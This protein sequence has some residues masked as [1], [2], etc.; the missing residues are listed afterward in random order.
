[1][2]VRQEQAARAG[3]P[4]HVRQL[5]FHLEQLPKTGDTSR[6][7]EINEPVAEGAREV[8]DSAVAEWTNYYRMT[9]WGFWIKRLAAWGW[10]LALPMVFGAWAAVCLFQVRLR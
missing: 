4:E 10:E 9:R 5:V 8:A 2:F 7:R 1:M 6:W 3:V